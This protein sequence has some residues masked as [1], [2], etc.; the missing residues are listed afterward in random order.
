MFLPPAKC[1][2]SVCGTSHVTACKYS[3]GVFYPKMASASSGT[4]IVKPRHKETLVPLPGPTS[5]FFFWWL[6]PPTHTHT[7]QHVV[8]SRLGL[9]GVSPM[10]SELVA[11]VNTERQPG[12]CP[13]HQ[14]VNV[15]SRMWDVVATGQMKCVE[16]T[17]IP[18]SGA[19]VGGGG[20]LPVWV[21][22][23]S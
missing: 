4:N 23:I 11:G 7:C 20:W 18:R 17:F 22:Y 19:T 8:F 12:H 14:L 16:K 9:C 15:T 10:T 3:H 5:F 2:F 1:V 13:V 21:G 6:P